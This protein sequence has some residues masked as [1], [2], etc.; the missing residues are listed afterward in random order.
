[1]AKNSAKNQKTDKLDPAKTVM[2]G[3]CILPAGTPKQKSPYGEPMDPTVPNR[4][5]TEMHL[6]ARDTKVP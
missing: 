6:P 4:A 5:H 3:K 1:M 2:G